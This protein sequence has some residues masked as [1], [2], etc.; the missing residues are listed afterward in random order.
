M[1]KF[2][3]EKFD[4]VLMESCSGQVSCTPSFDMTSIM[5]LEEDE[6]YENMMLFAQVFCK[7]GP[8]ELAKKNI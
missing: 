8:E 5:P 2:D 4:T 7:Q 6:R 3:R 1:K